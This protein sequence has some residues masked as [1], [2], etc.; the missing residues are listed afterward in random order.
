M[1]EGTE[2]LQRLNSGGPFPM[3]TSCCPAWVTM[4][5]KSY[6]HLMKHLSSAR[7]PQQMLGSLVKSYFAKKLGVEKDQVCMV[8][9][10][11]CTAKKHESQR[12]EFLG[13]VD[14]VLTTRELGHLLRVKHVPVNSLPPSEFDQPL[15]LS[16]GAAT[17]FGVTGGV[18]EAAIRTAQEASG[19]DPKDVLPLGGLS[20]VR[21]LEGVKAAN[22]KLK[23]QN[24]D[25]VEVR[26]GVVHGSGHVRHLLEALEKNE[27]H[28]DFIE[29]MS[30]PGGC[31]G[32]GGQPKSKNPDILTKRMQAIYTA[33]QK[34]TFR[35]SHEN[36]AIKQIYEDFLGAPLSHKSHELLHTS[37]HDRSK[38]Q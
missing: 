19:L 15:G 25:V 30:C 1:E 8:S 4:V 26:V 38:K 31:I 35:K 37:Y 13:D 23:K 9:I 18:M 27:E 29:V 28:F 24:G 36:P 20:S 5:E 22:V 16:S 7:S 3:F 2:L 14:Y 33:D 21:G 32:G 11:P 6:P 12:E 10:M 34:S 17:L